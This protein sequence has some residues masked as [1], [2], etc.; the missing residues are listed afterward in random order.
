MKKN[1]RILL[2]GF[3]ATALLA[4]CRTARV[5]DASAPMEEEDVLMSRFEQQMSTAKAYEKSNQWEQAYLLYR[6]LQTDTD[7]PT[8]HRSLQLKAANALFMAGR[9][10]AALAALSPMPEL[11]GSLHDAKKLALA[12]R[13]LQKMDGKP[14]HVEAL[15]EIALD[16]SFEGRDADMFRAAGYAELGRVYFSN[17]K[18]ARAAKCFEYASELFEALHDE[19][20]AE[21][22]R[23]IAEYLR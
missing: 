1:N 22:C 21:T 15:L 4:G 11:P 17:S 9:Y 3:L 7:D 10:P 16:N 18:N 13:I 8:V 23:H 2:V 19:E 20:Q 14:E 5:E 12:A 6:D